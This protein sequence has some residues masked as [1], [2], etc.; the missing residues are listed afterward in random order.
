MRTNDTSGNEASLTAQVGKLDRLTWASAMELN[1][2]M[3]TATEN[4]M[5]T[6][7]AGFDCLEE[8]RIRLQARLGRSGSRAVIEFGIL[9]HRSCGSGEVEGQMMIGRDRG[10]M[11]SVK[12]GA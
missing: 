1:P 12:L 9:R 8:C 7:V 5:M 3:A 11:N 10:F 2:A 6:I 4:F